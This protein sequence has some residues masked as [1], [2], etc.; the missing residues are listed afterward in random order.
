[1]AV[2]IGINIFYITFFIYNL[3]NLTIL[4]IYA[5]N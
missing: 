3:I 5:L 4:K 1:M 2:N